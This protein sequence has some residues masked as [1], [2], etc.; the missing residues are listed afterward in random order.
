[1]CD[2]TRLCLLR[3]VAGR[4]YISSRNKGGFPPLF[5]DAL[6]PPDVFAALF[7]LS[8]RFAPLCYLPQV[9]LRV[10][11]V[12]ISTLRE[13]SSSLLPTGSLSRK[14]TLWDFN[15]QRGKSPSATATGWL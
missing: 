15:S 11:P 12:V 13:G 1:M 6:Y 10:A 14:N 2:W 5:H 9:R 4:K 3:S 7:Q 8:E